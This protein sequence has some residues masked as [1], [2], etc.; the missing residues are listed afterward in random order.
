M[1][2]SQTPYFIGI[3]LPPA[4]DEQIASYKTLLHKEIVHSLR[5]LVPHITLLHPPSL[6]GVSSEDLLPEIRKIAPEFLPLT[7]KL[8]PIGAFDGTVLYIS[9]ESSELTALQ[10]R[11]VNLIPAK[12]REIY[13][14]REFLP[15]ITLV[16]AGSPHSLDID[17]LSRQTSRNLTLPSYFTVHSVSLFTRR[18]PREYQIG[19]I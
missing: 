19:T 16:Q 7:L 4:L 1:S 15:H 3:A 14:R 18:N 6:R 11:L 2:G 13:T 17:S 8:G 5:P 9:I 10:S 12:A